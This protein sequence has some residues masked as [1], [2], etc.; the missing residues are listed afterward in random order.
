[1]RE[2]KKIL[3]VEIKD[4]EITLYDKDRDFVAAAI[5]M[6]GMVSANF[7]IEILRYANLG[8]TIYIVN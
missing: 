6:D 8:Y 5:I 4:N 1:M 3:Y 7:T 2:N